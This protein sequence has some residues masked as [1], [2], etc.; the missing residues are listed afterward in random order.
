MACLKGRKREKK[1]KNFFVDRI[2]R[3]ICRLSGQYL[4]ISGQS[5]QFDQSGQN[6][7]NP[8]NPTAHPRISDE[9]FFLIRMDP[10]NDNPADGLIEFIQIAPLH[11]AIRVQIL[12]R[13]NSFPKR[14]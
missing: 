3:I 1:N 6:P 14:R 12:W 10:I 7:I 11:I 13:V 4:R 2:E 9:P 5:D 8:I